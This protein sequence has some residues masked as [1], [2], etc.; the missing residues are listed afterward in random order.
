MDLSDHLNSA[1]SV[2]PADCSK[3]FGQLQVKSNFDLHHYI[4]SYLDGTVI[5]EINER[6]TVDRDMFD[7]CQKCLREMQ[8]FLKEKAL[9]EEEKIK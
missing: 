8:E 2:I 6:Q 9:S 7:A 4:N 5:I 1:I 3:D